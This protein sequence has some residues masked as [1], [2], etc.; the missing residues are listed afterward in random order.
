MP[1]SSNVL[2]CIRKAIPYWKFKTPDMACQSADKI[3]SLFSQYKTEGNFVG[4]DMARKFL[5]MGYTR[6]RR[7]ANHKSGRKY[8]SGSKTVL[9]REEDPIK[10]QSAKIFYEKWQ[11][12]KSDPAY[13]RLAARHRDQYERTATTAAKSSSSSQEVE[14]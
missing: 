14:A 13:V 9:P 7:Y 6:S 12:A 10:A 1:L 5:Q 4:M 8:A 3:Y 11:L 2:T